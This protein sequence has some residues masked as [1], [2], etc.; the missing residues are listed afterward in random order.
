MDFERYKAEVYTRLYQKP[1]L[2]PRFTSVCHIPQA[3]REYDDNYFIV[4]NT[5]TE[6][7]EL[8]S[9]E[10]LDD[11]YGFTIPFPELDTRVIKYCYKCDIKRRG[12]EIFDEMDSHNRKLRDYKEKKRR[13]EIHDQAK[14]MAWGFKKLAWEM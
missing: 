7:Y 5:L 6:K 3:V 2:I 10:N 8:H 13:E 4:Y 1:H 9:L 11:S 14:E 12:M